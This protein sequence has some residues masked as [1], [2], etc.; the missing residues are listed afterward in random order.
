[1]CFQ[2]YFLIPLITIMVLG[3]QGVASEICSEDVPTLVIKSKDVVRKVPKQR[4]YT[5]GLIFRNGSLFESA[6]MYGESKLIQINPKNGTEV[7]LKDLNEDFFAEGLAE[8]NSQLYQLTW[9]EKKVLIYQTENFADPETKSFSGEGWGLTSFEEKL[10]LSDGSAVLKFLNPGDLSVVRDVSVRLGR[11]SL[12][13]INEVEEING[14]I[15]A[16]IYGK[17]IVVVINPKNGCVNTKLDLAELIDAHKKEIVNSEGAICG[18]DPCHPYDFVANGIAFDAVT[19]EIYLTG[20][21]WPMI[22]VI[23]NPISKN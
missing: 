5:Q 6:G 7:V 4:H 23:K 10:V 8:I 2:R 21:N 14:Q 19:K 22:F 20:K 18:S 16:N 3:V 9:R 12:T 1:M 13:A 11:A 17:S 15:F